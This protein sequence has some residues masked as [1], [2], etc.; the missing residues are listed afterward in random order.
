MAVTYYTSADTS[1]PVLTGTT[2]ALV[3][4]LDAILVN[5][6][7]SKAAAGWSIEYTASNKRVYRPASGT[8]FRLRVVDD[9]SVAGSAA[10]EALVRAAESASGVDTL[11]DAFPTTALV[12]D[13]ACVWR[14][15]DSADSTA[16][17]WWAIATDSFLAL[18]VRFTSSTGDWYIFGDIH[19]LHSADSYA[20]ILSTRASGN[21]S[22]TDIVMG[23]ADNDLSN[24]NS[25]T[26]L[27]LARTVNGVTKS[28]GATIFRA[29]S[30]NVGVASSAM[31][32]PGQGAKLMLCPIV[33]LSSGQGSGTQSNNKVLRGF[34]PYMFE[35]LVAPSPSN[36]AHEDTFTASDYDASSSFVILSSNALTDSRAR[37]ALQT[38]G[39][40]DP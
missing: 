8:R 11:T 17:S 14:K 16:R 6:Y 30:S 27:W 28:E 22:S 7:G 10:R 39:P 25:R 34:L 2:G 23:N 1:A 38:A 15:S 40:F 33:I 9:G 20:C 35:A 3:A 36:L 4:L 5:G 24:G 13:S 18:F 21:D 32:Y 37:V 31:I 19:K 12:S 29:G 26:R